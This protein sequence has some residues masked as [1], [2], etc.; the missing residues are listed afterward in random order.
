[1]K[2]KSLKLTHVD[3]KMHH[4]GV[5]END[6][7]ENVLLVQTPGDVE[8]AARILDKSEYRGMW[9]EYL[10]YTGEKDGVPITVMS[11]GMG[12]MPMA[13]TVEELKHLGVKNIIKIGTGG[14][15]QPGVEPGTL[16]VGASA[17][18]GEGATL[19]YI[20]YQYPAV[21]DIGAINALVNASKE[22]NEKPIVGL[23]RSHDAAYLENSTAREK[24]AYWSN[25]KVDLVES[26]TSTLLTVAALLRDMHV[27]SL[28][29]AEE[30]Y[31]DETVI[32]EDKLAERI[33]LCAKIAI[34][35]LQLMNGK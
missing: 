1:M 2:Y 6:V 20:N 11:S 9:R 10:T 15:L 24:I 19:E 33:D 25:L 21:A 13:I 14:A 8:N 16:F 12:C 32:D 5:D 35:A 4:L 28:Y 7:V 31:L 23:F 29:V 27:A 22:F 18:R 26:E 3:G 30:N 34:R 17:V